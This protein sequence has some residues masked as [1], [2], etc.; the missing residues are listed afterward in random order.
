MSTTRGYRFKVRGRKFQG[1]VRGK[2]FHRV[3]GA[4]NAL[5][6]EVEEAGIL[7]TFKRHLDGSMNREGREGYGPNKGRSFFFS[8]VRAS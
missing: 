5:P 2:V 8:S 4:W 6:E 3:M 1:D 7:A